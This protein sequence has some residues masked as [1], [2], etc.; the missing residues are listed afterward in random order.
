VKARIAAL[1]LFALAAATGAHSQTLSSVKLD[2]AA[3]Q[4]GQPVTATIALDVAENANCGVRWYWGDGAT[5]DIKVTD[6][7]ALPIKLTHTYAK[8]GDYRTMAEGKKV[9]SHLACAG[10]N[11]VTMLKV[12][13]PPPPVAAAPAPAP[14]PAPAVA[15]ASGPSCPEGWKL[16]TSSK[17]SGTYTCTAKAGTA[18]PAAKPTCPGDLTY[19]ENG[20]KGQLG[21]QK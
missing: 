11:V 10:K 12:A 21:C 17:K 8:G 3:P 14:A 19:F 18:L 6:K 16:K 13:A 9:T 4:A 20:K 7:N 5:E 15:K 2:P 1:A